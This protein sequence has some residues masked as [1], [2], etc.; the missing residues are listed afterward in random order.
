MMPKINI[1]E[2]LAGQFLRITAQN[3]NA[4]LTGTI[5]HASTWPIYNIPNF[6]KLIAEN[7]A[8]GA[9]KE[10]KAL[11][12]T[13]NVKSSSEV[14]V[15]SVDVTPAKDS[16][17]STSDI[18]AIV[19]GLKSGIPNYFSKFGETINNISPGPYVAVYEFAAPVT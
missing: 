17:A 3:V 7:N 10:I 16:T 4:D 5:E 14:E 11:T 2:N 8:K 1:L 12:I 13:L 6:R 15:K 18:A 9:A 19:S